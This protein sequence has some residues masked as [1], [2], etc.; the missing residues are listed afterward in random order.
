MHVL[1]IGWTSVRPSVTRWYCIKT[2]E[3]IVMLSYHTIAHSF[4]FCVYQGLSEIPTGSPPAGPL[5]RWGVKMSQFSTNTR[6]RYIAISEMVE[7]RWVYT[8][9]HFTS[10][11]SSFQPCDIYR[12]CPMGVTREGQNVHIAVNNLVTYELQL[13]IFYAT[14]LYDYLKFSDSYSWRIN[15]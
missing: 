13:D 3:H 8:A 6:H 5:N 7:D 4:S 1:V 14:E 2:A 9:R 10:I 11:E 12:D 15:K